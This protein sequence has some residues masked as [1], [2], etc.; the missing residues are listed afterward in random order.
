[1]YIYIYIMYLY[2]YT[3]RLNE[4]LQIRQVHTENLESFCHIDKNKI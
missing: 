4:C 2:N 1:M 3:F